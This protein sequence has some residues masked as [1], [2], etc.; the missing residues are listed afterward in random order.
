MA[1]WYDFLPDNTPLKRGLDEISE[2]SQDPI[3]SYK[4][5]TRK[6]G[7]AVNEYLSDVETA[8]KPTGLVDDLLGFFKEKVT[9]YPSGAP[10]TEETPTIDKILSS[11][12]NVSNFLVNPD[13]PAGDISMGVGPALKS[14]SKLAGPSA[15]TFGKVGKITEP[16]APSITNPVEIA[17]GLSR[18]DLMALRFSKERDLPPMERLAYAMKGGPIPEM[19]I[20]DKQAAY[21]LWKA[22]AKEADI[23]VTIDPPVYPEFTVNNKTVFQPKDETLLDVF[24]TPATTAVRKGN[25][26]AYKTIAEIQMTEAEIK[27]RVLTRNVQDQEF[28]GKVGSQ[29]A[30]EI[31]FQMRTK[32]LPEALAKMT[33]QEQATALYIRGKFDK[34]R[35]LIKT[36]LREDVRGSID[37]KIRKQ[38]ANDLT[39]TEA[40]LQGKINL[41]VTSRVPDDWGID[42]YLPEIFPGEYLIRDKKGSVLGSAHTKF[43]AK[44]TI[45]DLI[46]ESGGD[47]KA[48]DLVVSNRTYYDADNVRDYRGGGATFIND[49][50]NAAGLTREEISKAADGVFG[51]SKGKEKVWS[52]LLKRGKSPGFTKDISVAMDIYNRGMERWIHLSELSRKVEPEVAKLTSKGFPVLARTIDENMKALWGV[53]NEVSQRLDNELQRIP[54]VKN[55]VAPLALERWSGGLKSGIVALMIKYKPS[56]HAMN[57]SQLLTTTWPVASSD[58]LFNGVKLFNSKSGQEILKNYGIGSASRTGSGLGPIEDYNQGVAFLTM[59][60]KGMKLGLES[61]QAADFAFLRGNIYS[62]FHSLQ[63][64][65]PGVFRKF[66]PA[67]G[68]TIFQRFGVKQIEQLIDI[69]KD[70][71]V[72]G[73]AKWLTT[74][75][76]M[77]GMRALTLGGGGWLGVQAYKAIE[78][79]FGKSVADTIHHGLPSLVGVDMSNSAMAFNPPFG[80]SLAEKVGNIALGPLGSVMTSGLTAALN[81]KGVDPSM[82]GRVFQAMVSRV[83]LAKEFDAI[84]RI[85]LNDYDLKTSDGKAKYKADTTDL[86]K[87]ALGFRPIKDSDLTRLTDNIVMARE[88]RDSVLDYAASRYGAAMVTGLGVPQELR[89]AIQKDVDNW[90]A[91]FPEMAIT[92]TDIATR[93]KGRVES[94]TM[95]YKQRLLKRTGKVGKAFQLDEQRRALKAQ[96]GSNPA[97]GGGGN[98]Y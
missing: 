10:A 44:T 82:S 56:F 8:A 95:D 15:K 62:Q 81:N 90:N 71:N 51:A 91:M 74:V 58:E 92:G 17:E 49:L 11:I 98:E 38:F 26:D 22:A 50:T 34:D 69:A 55:L 25:L 79:Q 18:G 88:K 60:N 42:E 70:K 54:G 87:M 67:G 9:A 36:K 27:K 83:P 21:N 23:P 32:P 53:R 89:E 76:L 5:G 47:L 96:G 37:R 73:A 28:L 13:S 65:R 63:T 97:G 45:K 43:Q 77:G 40:D 6:I 24:G 16:V 66:D 31:A 29:A 46:E 84:R 33:H 19:V 93:T 2:I 39:L 75:G 41:A 59:Y 68:L 7:D 52:N 12:Y 4:R 14:A 94:Q 86:V 3:E 85:I 35:D 20:K 48:D 72:S 78:D 57:A 80:S 61:R 1:S 64:D 30:N